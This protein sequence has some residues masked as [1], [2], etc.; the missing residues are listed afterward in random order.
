MFNSQEM[1]TEFPACFKLFPSLL[2]DCAVFLQIIFGFGLFTVSWE[3]EHFKLCL[4][5]NYHR[6]SIIYFTAFLQLVKVSSVFVFIGRGLLE[7]DSKSQEDQYLFEICLVEHS[8]QICHQIA[9]SCVSS[10]PS[11]FTLVPA[12]I[13]YCIVSAWK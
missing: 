4:F 1:F 13:S 6:Y 5:W 11:Q 2:Q 8:A 7:Q 3:E 9:I 10:Y 12:R